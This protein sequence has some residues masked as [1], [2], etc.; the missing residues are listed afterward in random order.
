MPLQGNK[1]TERATTKKAAHVAILSIMFGSFV[2]I[3]INSLHIRGSSDMIAMIR[4]FST[5]NY[6]LCWS[7]LQSQI[8]QR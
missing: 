6:I 7:V 8:N 5:H 3:S 1:K 4:I 2:V